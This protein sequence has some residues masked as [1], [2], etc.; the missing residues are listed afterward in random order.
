MPRNRD[1]NQVGEATQH[2]L[3]LPTPLV[4]LRYQHKCVGSLAAQTNV[5]QPCVLQTK[6][7]REAAGH[8]FPRAVVARW[9]QVLWTLRRA[10]GSQETS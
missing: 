6:A 2:G 9:C 3:E 4:E 7:K 8:G 1:R 10:Y 5:S